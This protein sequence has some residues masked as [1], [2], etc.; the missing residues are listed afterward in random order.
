MYGQ[1]PYCGE[2]LEAGFLRSGRSFFWT[3]HG[4]RGA[5]GMVN[6]PMLEG[7]FEPP[8]Q[9]KWDAV[10]YPA[11][12]CKKCGLILLPVQKENSL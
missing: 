12:Y 3:P 9:L 7:E 6:R 11:E 10:C 8:Y 5:W 1:C 4:K 2:S